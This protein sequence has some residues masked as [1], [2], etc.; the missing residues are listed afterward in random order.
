MIVIV[1]VMPIEWERVLLPIYRAGPYFKISFFFQCT[2]VS[3]MYTTR[4][5][6]PWPAS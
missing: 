3:P 1:I 6:Y 5:S 2:N 4:G